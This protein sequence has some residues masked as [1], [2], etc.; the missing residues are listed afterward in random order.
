MSIRDAS[1]DP[2]A[3]P[4]LTALYGSLLASEARHHAGYVQ[5]AEAVDGHGGATV[6]RRLEA[7]AAHEA[8]ALSAGEPRLHADPP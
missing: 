5:L 6:R 2:H 1:A 4:A 3:D 8:T 7:I